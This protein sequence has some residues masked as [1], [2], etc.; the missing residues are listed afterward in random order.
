MFIRLSTVFA[1]L[2]GLTALVNAGVPANYVALARE[3]SSEL[4]QR[5]PGQQR[6]RFSFAPNL[7]MSDLSYGTQEESS[8]PF[9]RSPGQERVRLLSH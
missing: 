8:E 9:Q 5:Q 1:V 7:V 3:E 6:V 2:L 4:L